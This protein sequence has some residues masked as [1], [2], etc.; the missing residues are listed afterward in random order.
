[1]GPIGAS[2]RIGLWFLWSAV[3]CGPGLVEGPSRVTDGPDAP[4]TEE[5][6]LPVVDDA[7]EEIPGWCLNDGSCETELCRPATT[8]SGAEFICVM[9]GPK[10]I[11]ESCGA[12]QQC[13]SQICGTPTGQAE[14]R[15]LLPCE[16]NG[17]CPP[18]APYCVA[19]D[20]NSL[21]GCMPQTCCADDCAN[22]YCTCADECVPRNCRLSA[23]CAPGDQCRRKPWAPF[24]GACVKPPPD[25]PTCEASEFVTFDPSALVGS[26]VHCMTEQPCA[27]DASCEPQ[28]TCI[29]LSDLSELAGDAR[30][31]GRPLE[32]P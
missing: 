9:G 4:D 17:D 31:C 14:R 19:S 5:P 25:L 18:T 7:A 22:G 29:T 3:A 24:Q 6:D 11:G 28:Y 10:T 2:G 20:D 8:Q 12:S 30:F 13:E 27:T 32:L 15:C 26:P 23:D 21:L 1:M 16:A